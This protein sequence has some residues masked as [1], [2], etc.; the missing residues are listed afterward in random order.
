MNLL[1]D[2]PNTHPLRRP[3]PDEAPPSSSGT[4]DIHF[5]VNVERS[6]GTP[7]R[8]KRQQC[9]VRFDSPDVIHEIHCLGDYTDR[10]IR[11]CWY[12]EEEYYQ[13]VSECK[14]AVRE[15]WTQRNKDRHRQE[16]GGP[17]EYYE[18][19]AS[20]NVALV[21]RVCSGGT[22]L[23][24]G[25]A[26]DD[27]NRGLEFEIDR[28][29]ISARVRH[30][31]WS[32][33]MAQAISSSPSPPFRDDD[34]EQRAKKRRSIASPF[35]QT[36]KWRNENDDET[37]GRKEWQLRRAYRPFS[38]LASQEARIRAVMDQLAVT[39]DGVA[40]ILSIMTSSSSSAPI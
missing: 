14:E 6:G 21:D 3:P 38:E 26:T 35:L 27:P 32:V 22:L 4:L 13:I 25:A 1:I 31:I 2:R 18:Q 8:G 29:R 34:E 24:R 9:R 39:M 37:L 10:E 40:N 23:D 12:R 16:G 20:Q 7:P 5:K 17:T 11:D 33:L 30:S 19:A 36:G 15:H 28:D